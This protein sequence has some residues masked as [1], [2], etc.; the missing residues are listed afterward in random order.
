M[1]REQ[2]MTA[3]KQAVGHYN[4]GL[5]DEEAVVKSAEAN[6][7]NPDQTQR[8]LEVYNTTKTICFFK[9][10][11][12][13]T[14]EFSIA[15]PEKVM[16]NLFSQDRMK[17]ERAEKEAHTFVIPD[18]SEYDRPETEFG[19]AAEAIEPL[20]KGTFFDKD[21][22]QIARSAYT[23]IDSVKQSADHCAST[24]GMCSTKYQLVMNKLAEHIRQDYFNPDKFSEALTF[25]KAAHDEQAE[26]VINDL[27][28]CLP[29]AYRDKIASDELVSD[30]NERH[31][32]EAE[33]FKQAVDLKLDYA[34]MK[35][36]EAEFRSMADEYTEQ[37]K[38]ASAMNDDAEED[39]FFAPGLREKVAKSTY[40]TISTWDQL[41]NAKEPR[42]AT[43]DKALGDVFGMMSSTAGEIAKKEIVPAIT[44]S[45]KA[46]KISKQ[47]KLTERMRNFQR[48]LI[49][50]D[51]IVNDPVLQGMDPQNVA[52]AYET[53]MRIAPDMSMNKEVVRSVLRA[54]TNAEATSPFDAKVLAELENE[55]KKQTRPI[56]PP[57]S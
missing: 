44:E 53:V 21:M 45:L 4:D 5:S 6:D 27:L 50:E 12:D 28:A 42:K 55:V 39:D 37:F 33:L 34:Q 40:Q 25:F 54:A 22:D 23:L 13:R 8:L 17:E 20:K 41:T 36:C 2:L 52:N 35:A 1:F 14:V 15:N 16:G 43:K 46:P 49:L 30:F 3:L 24:A 9:T 18:Y 48:Q 51:L 7:F 32:I 10:A 19:K 47:E 38:E 31:A 57:Q 11:D 29:D 26:P 56:P